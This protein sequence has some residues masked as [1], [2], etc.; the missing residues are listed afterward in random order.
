MD[1]CVGVGTALEAVLLGVVVGAVVWVPA[2][3]GVGDELAVEGLG[4]LGVEVGVDVLDVCVGVWVGV[5]VGVC[6]CVGVGV[7]VDDR[8]PRPGMEVRGFPSVPPVYVETAR[9][10][11]I[12]KV[13]MILS[14]IH[15]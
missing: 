15:I 9:P 13:T 11:T 4:V 7:P 3:V 12:S 1:A 8:P 14:L 6:V 2:T 10:V 5:R